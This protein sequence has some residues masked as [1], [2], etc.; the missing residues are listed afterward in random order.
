MPV[1]LDL[2]MEATDQLRSSRDNAADSVEQSPKK[3][4][5]AD[6]QRK[7]IDC[8]SG[9]LLVWTEV[10]SG[11]LDVGVAE[12]VLDGYDVATIFKEAGGIAMAKLVQSC[13]FDLCTFRDFLQAAQHL[14]A[15]E[16][17]PLP[18]GENPIRVP[19]QVA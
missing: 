18:A 8:L 1:S 10:L 12:E 7:P 13:L 16:A 9:A 2:V 4:R 19:R 11:C 6:P 3:S 17:I 14:V 5:R 15:P